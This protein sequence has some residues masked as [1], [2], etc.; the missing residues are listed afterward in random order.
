MRRIFCLLAVLCSSLFAFATQPWDGP[1]LSADPDAIRQAAD[2]IP[3]PAAANAQVLFHQ[4]RYAYDAQGRCVQ[5]YQLV[6]RVL[7]SAGVDGWSSIQATWSPWYQKKPAIRVRVINPDGSVHPLEP[8][9][10]AESPVQ[11][12]DQDIY[13]DE[14]QL[15]APLPAVTA[16][17]IIEEE[18]VTTDTAPFFDA[19]GLEVMYFGYSAPSVSSRLVVEVPAGTPL[20]CKP[21]LLKNL[22][23]QELTKDGR[24]TVTFESGAIDALDDPEPNRPG[25][26]PG[27]PQVR[28]STAASW[29]AVA[30]RYNSIVED[31]LAGID[32][33]SYIS[34]LKAKKLDRAALIQAVV[35]QLHKDVRYTGIEFG[36]SS[37][38]PH[39][40]TEVLHSHYGD[41]KDK[42]TLLVAMLR[43][44]GVPAYV[45]LLHAGPAFDVSPE[46]P[47]FGM[48]DHA[49]VYVP[50]PTRAQDLWIDATDEFARID[51]LHPNDQGRLAL[52]VKPDTTGL[53]ATSELPST[54]D[55]MVE[56][57]E[58]Y[59]AESGPSRVVEISEPHG[60]I[61][62][63]Y[64]GWYG[65]ADTKDIHKRLE[66]YVKSTYLAD[67]LT[68]LEHTSADDMAKP[69]R[70]TLEAEKAR[71]AYVTDDEAT[72]YVPLGS[73]Y[74]RLPEFIRNVPQRDSNHKGNPDD[75]RKNDA[76]IRNFVTEWQIKVVPPAGF[77]PRPLPPDS[78][79]PIGPAVLS[80][81]YQVGDD[82]AVNAVFRFDSVRARWTA[83]EVES[84]R[85]A[86]RE[87]ERADSPAIHFDLTAAADLQRGNVRKALGEYRTLIALHPSEALHH[88]QLSR[89]LLEAGVGDAARDEARRATQL[90]P[91]SARAWA[92]LAWVLQFDS[93]GRRWG[94]GWDMAGA[95]A[96]YQKAIA[97]DPDLTVAAGN[98]G[99]L[100]ERD[101]RGRHYVDKARLAKAID[102][103]Q[104]I[105]DKLPD[106]GLDDNLVYALFFAERYQDCLN[107][108][109]KLDSS[110]S[111][112]QLLTASTAALH[113]VAAAADEAGRQVTGQEQRT[114]L[115]RDAADLL[116]SQRR[117]PVA[118]DLITE[119]ARGQQ[120]PAT[121]LAY[122]NNLR[123]TQPLDKQLYPA[124]D[125]R[126]IVQEMIL[127]LSGANDETPWSYF[128]SKHVMPKARFDKKQDALVAHVRYR[129]YSRLSSN[130]LPF[131]ATL[132][133]ALSNLTMVAD[134][135]PDFGYRVRL[136]S[137]TGFD[138]TYYVVLEDTAF[139]V[140]A[141]VYNVPNISE[142]ALW[143]LE[144][145]DLAGARRWLDWEREVVKPTGG[146]DPLADRAFPHFW[147]RGQ[148][149]DAAAIRLACAVSL[150]GTDENA[151]ALS[152]LLAAR[153]TV[154]PAQQTYIDV[155]LL[156]AYAKEHRYADERALAQRLA[157]ANP[158]SMLALSSLAAAERALGDS[159]DVNQLLLARLQK[160]PG[161]P[162]TIREL[163][164]VA[165]GRGDYRQA[166]AYSKQLIDAGRATA[167]D[168]NQYAWYLLVGNMDLAEAERAAELGKQRDPNDAAL[169]HTLASLYAENGKTREAREVILKT[170]E[171]WGLEEPNSQSWYVLG[172][173]AEQY[174][175]NDVAAAAYQRVEK[176][177]E[178]WMA[179]SDSWA[180]AQR[181]LAAMKSG[182]RPAT[183]R[184]A[185]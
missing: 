63:D 160:L 10:V 2:A 152:I 34:A 11:D 28:F 17:S 102:V 157:A 146:D 107:E 40:P 38:V 24:K 47:G 41:C 127:Y 19:G 130:R 167:I 27:W 39:T 42:S 137:T 7:T 182:P 55:F 33:S 132:D 111:R 108:L 106:I 158:D 13:S 50:G 76:V 5:T 124:S 31:K 148:D 90:E 51:A 159:S 123:K 174:G 83:A 82:G 71:R 173:I 60:P 162:E 110:E 115:L 177:E 91:K 46:L 22:S 97:L 151:E 80:A 16:G 109:K 144:Q 168:L 126:R 94:K 103:Y 89:G 101:A 154:P 8:S 48:F 85:D 138:E 6:Y 58:Y 77:S 165:A 105:H 113:G 155:A 26:V 45:A 43:A 172:R 129:T 87:L 92:N 73:I 120:D 79:T 93:I 12:E 99:I 133:S 118:A 64:R 121:L 128:Y 161:D 170:M 178:A 142:Y 116:V 88:S 62:A 36:Q 70:L 179:A 185:R 139:R 86:I 53:T 95:D 169:L 140:V 81:H 183:Q 61:E 35:E 32:V 74:D 37:I 4:E 149:G 143:R 59:L 125:P 14:R 176:P 135:S 134:G 166:A 98:Y 171:L 3:K 15:R 54:A 72:V 184:A 117:Y 175:L 1:A 180:L 100:L 21:F 145:G 136:Q 153:P 84:A 23:I 96:A 141:T 25:D 44:V 163:A 66:E 65:G 119:A 57:R 112:R 29:Q 20:Q 52:I 78:K 156:R 181:R 18:V 150:A 30:T 104:S 114:K 68:K 131:E 122:A 69:F 49:I 67:K 75:K 9:A 56:R 147:T 164:E